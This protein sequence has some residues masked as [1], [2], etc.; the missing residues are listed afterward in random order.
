MGVFKIV[1]LILKLSCGRRVI[2]D[3]ANTSSTSAGQ[4]SQLFT[5]GAPHPSSPALT[6]KGGGCFAGRRIIAFKDKFGFN[7][8]DLVP[9][10]LVP[11]KFSHPNIKTMVVNPKGNGLRYEYACG[12]NPTRIT[13]PTIKLHS[14]ENYMSIM[15]R[16]PS[17]QSRAKHASA[18]GLAVSYEKDLRKVRSSV[19]AQGW[20]L[21]GTSNSGEDVSHLMQQPGSN[22]CILTFEGSDSPSDWITNF[23][24]DRVGFCGGIARAHEGFTKE[25]NKV[26]TS[27]SWQ[28]SI[29]PK[30]GKCSEVDVVGHSLGGAVAS[31]F[32]ACADSGNGSAEYKLISW[33]R[34]VPVSMPGI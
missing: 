6:R 17:S 27:S 31:L 19:N 22:R 14:K 28:N 25:L 5:F 1:L 21:V 33:Q 7:Q 34:Q 4:I 32:A 2:R 30:L 23:K 11:T 29:R 3:I 12:E 24:V 13:R 26:V 16:F 15:K 10:L 20:R 9:T 18:V 8:E